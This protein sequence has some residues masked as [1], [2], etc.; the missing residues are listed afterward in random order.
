M[1]KTI[2][3]ENLTFIREKGLYFSLYMRLS[4]HGWVGRAKLIENQM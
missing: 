4:T 2:I 1:E 3:R